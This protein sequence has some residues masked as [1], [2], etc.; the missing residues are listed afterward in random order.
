MQM[1]RGMKIDEAKRY[2]AEKLGVSIEELTDP[3]IMREI[4]Q[5]FNLGVVQSEMGT[6]QGIEAKHHIARLLDIDINSLRVFSER[7]E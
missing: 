7:T 3:V 2:T 5:E 4:R 6:A 1:I